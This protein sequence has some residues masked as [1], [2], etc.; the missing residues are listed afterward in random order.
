MGLGIRSDKHAVLSLDVGPVD[1]KLNIPS[2]TQIS[3]FHL[4]E[5]CEKLMPLWMNQTWRE[6]WQKP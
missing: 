6:T 3:K 5:V 2:L 4:A 1:L